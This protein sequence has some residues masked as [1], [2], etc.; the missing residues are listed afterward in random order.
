LSQNMADSPLLLE[1]LSSH[2]FVRINRF[3]WHD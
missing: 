1:G 2:S 3:E